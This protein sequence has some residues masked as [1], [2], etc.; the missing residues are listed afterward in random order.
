MAVVAT[1]FAVEADRLASGL[2]R[3]RRLGF[4]VMPGDH[5]RDHHGYL[6]GED[7]ARA[8]DLVRALRAPDVRAVWFARGGYGTSRILDRVPWR[9][10]ARQPKILVGYSDLTALFAP[11]VDRAGALCLYGPVLAELGDRDAWHAPSLR[12]LLAGQPVE[13]RLSAANVLAHG[14]ARGRLVGGNLTVLSH[15]CGTPY[16]P[17]CRGAILFLEDVGEPTYRIDRMLTQ[18]AHAGWLRGV[19]GVVLGQIQATRR[20]RFPPDRV[21][22]DV[23]AEA[24]LALGVPVV[25]GIVAGHV[26][27][28]R[29]LPIGG[30]AE[31]D[32]RAGMLRVRP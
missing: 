12:R 30:T 23:L 32:T 14:R 13:F 18:L 3:L 17:D 7:D 28:K 25:R 21:L 11:A 26:A 2:A 1:G 5:V 15:S 6:A 19:A 27:K 4:R 9:D 24:F 8:A 22:D 20:R 10:L 16:E 29:T 31:I